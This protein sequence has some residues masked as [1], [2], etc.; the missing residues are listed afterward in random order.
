MSHIIIDQ[1]YLEGEECPED[2]ILAF[3]SLGLEWLEANT[4]DIYQ[5]KIEV[6]PCGSF[7]IGSIPF[8]RKLLSEKRNSANPLMTFFS[9]NLH[10][11]SRYQHIAPGHWWLNN[12]HIM[13][14]FSEFIRRVE[15]WPS[16]LGCSRLVIKPDFGLKSFETTILDADG[17]GTDLKRFIERAK[18]D[19][20]AVCILA[21]A[22]DIH[23]EYRFVVEKGRGVVAG[24]RY[25]QEGV[26]DSAPLDLIPTGAINLANK[27]K[28]FELPEEL[29]VVDVA[30]MEDGSFKLIEM[31]CLSTSGLYACDKRAVFEAVKRILFKD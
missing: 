29:V 2:F 25:I 5:D 10:Y 17:D 22:K 11:H 8:I 21:S 14:T 16:M 24:S 1:K 6:P 26:I 20:Q 9:A 7:A 19:P 4:V 30:L 18:V 23:A 15:I 12:D 27:A 31:N 13:V 3:K 28:D